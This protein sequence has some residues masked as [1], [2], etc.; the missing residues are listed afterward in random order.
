[1]VGEKNCEMQW[2]YKEFCDLK[3][4][5]LRTVCFIRSKSEMQYFLEIGQIQSFCANT[6]SH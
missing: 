4:Y 2:F 3:Q 1:M 6:I 5:I